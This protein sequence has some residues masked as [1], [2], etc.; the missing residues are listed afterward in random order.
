MHLQGCET[1]IEAFEQERGQLQSEGGS[2][3]CVIVLQP[4][5]PAYSAAMRRGACSRCA[6][7]AHPPWCRPQCRPPIRLYQA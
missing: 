1:L 7:V 6:L 5:E 4:G 3:G 2:S